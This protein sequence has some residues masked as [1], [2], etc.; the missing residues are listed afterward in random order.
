MLLNTIFLEL[1][2]NNCN[3]WIQPDTEVSEYNLVLD[4]H[5][6]TSNVFVFL[7]TNPFLKRDTSVNM[8]HIY[9][10]IVINSQVV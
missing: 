3:V 5:R 9:L 6:L 2:V 8:L 7:N 10:K 4:L 1:K